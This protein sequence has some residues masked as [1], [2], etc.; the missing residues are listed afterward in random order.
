MRGVL[1][2]VRV[3]DHHPAPKLPKDLLRLLDQLV[4]RPDVVRLVVQLDLAVRANGHAV[5]ELGQVLGHRE[6]VHA[7][8]HPGVIRPQ[9]N[10]RHDRL[11]HDAVRAALRLD[12]AQWIRRVRT[13]PV[14][15][16]DRHRLLEHGVVHPERMKPLHHRRQVRHVALAD[17]AGRVRESAWVLV[18]TGL[19]EQRRRV[20]GAAR[21]DHERSGNR[22]DALVAFDLDGLDPVTG[23]VGD[24]SSRERLRPQ[25]DVGMGG[26]RANRAHFRVALRVDLARE[27]I[28]G[29]A[30]DA[31]VAK[32]ERQREGIQPLAAELLDDTADE[33]GVFD[34]RKRERSTRAFRGIDA[35]LS[36]DRVHLFSAIVKRCQRVVVDGPRRRRAIHVLRF[37]EVLRTEPEQHRAPELCI[38]A[39]AVVSVGNKRLARRVEPGFGRSI[40]QVLPDRGGVPVLIFL[41][42]EVTAL[43][44]QDLASRRRELAREGAAAGAAADDDD[45]ERI[46]QGSGIRDQGSGI[47]DQGS[48]IREEY[49][50]SINA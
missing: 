40:A 44:D 31:M 3:R 35:G 5:L 46:H 8:R 38:S 32:A 42:D 4:V 1:G 26:C 28:A 41:R 43:D 50:W 34:W 21:H 27:R 13:L 10:L 39:D 20:H 49:T 47:R 24:Q 45:V 29:I 11:R 17:E 25:R 23:R 48:G 16:V 12:L 37:L 19:Q 2:P 7:T 15:V 33:R 22:L 18:A 36:V 9:R 14:E 30:E 6:P